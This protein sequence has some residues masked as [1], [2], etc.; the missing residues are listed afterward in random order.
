MNTV[1]YRTERRRGIAPL[2]DIYMPP[3]PRANVL[4]VHGGGLVVGSR[5]MR[6]MRVLAERFEREGAAVCSIDYRMMFRGGRLDEAV[7]DVR[8]AL[9]FWTARVGPTHVV[10]LSMGATLAM[11][12]VDDRITSLACCFGLYDVAHL[13]WLYR[14]MLRWRFDAHPRVP[15]LLV[16]GD[17]D[18]LVPVEQARRLA[19][20]RTALE[21]PTQLVVVPGA[22]HGFFTTPHAEAGIAAL[23]SH[24]MPA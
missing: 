22:P 8:A 3:A 13:P 9:A 5:R 11:L 16:H 24:M 19:A 15:T 7:D 2:A 17:A 4:L 14:R 21:L 12:A 10:G 18:R 20:Q 23:R 1:R 6:P